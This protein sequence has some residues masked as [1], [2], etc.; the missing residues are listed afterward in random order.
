MLSVPMHPAS[1]GLGFKP[2][3]FHEAMAETRPH[4]WWEV[5]PENHLVSGGPRLHMLQALAERHPLSLHSVSLS[6]ASPEPVDP[7]RLQG[8]QRLSRML[9][10]A[11]I[12]EH[13]AWSWWR[14]TYAPD[15][16][17]V[18]RSPL[19]LDQL[20]N[21]I[22][23]VQMALGRSIA[24]ENPSHYVPLP[25]EMDEVEFLHCVAHR[26]G[27]QLLVD[28]NNVAVSAHN[29]NQDPMDWLDR[30]HPH[31]VAEIHLAGHHADPMCGEALWIDG[32]DRPISE[33]VWHLYQHFIARI[34]PRP[35]LIERDD[36]LP[37]Y[38]TLQAE[39]DRARTV[40][41]ASAIGSLARPCFES[42]HV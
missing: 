28:V 5:H 18:R 25:H 22:D 12:S 29:L 30:I 39:A 16:W 13:L 14:G 10:P 32:H 17:P 2:A 21:N 37:P 15:L 26:S 35:T 31:L 1:V 27:C 42:T 4:Q 11:L 6:L 40:L 20:C 41:A 8:L 34:G 7:Q 9:Q 38:D 33:P 23:R 19:S 24:L 3:F 36:C